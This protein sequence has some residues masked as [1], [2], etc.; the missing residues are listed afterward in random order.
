MTI[1]TF[2]ENNRTELNGSINWSTYRYDGNG[3]VGTI[4]T[5]APTYND[6][7]IENWISN[8]ESLYNW[9]RSEGVDI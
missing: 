4:P 9:A 3:G 1:K 2:I 6:E 8:D 7:E 5:P